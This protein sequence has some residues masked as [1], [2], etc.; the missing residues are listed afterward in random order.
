LFFIQNEERQHIENELKDMNAH[1]T[2]ELNRCKQ[3]LDEREESLHSIESQ[4]RIVQGEKNQ[5]EQQLQQTIEILQADIVQCKLVT[6]DKV[7]RKI[8]TCM[9]IV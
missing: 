2:D 1:I 6:K 5:H 9:S 4:L 3:I 8:S 7:S